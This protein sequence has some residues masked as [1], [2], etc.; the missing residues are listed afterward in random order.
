[1][2]TSVVGKIVFEKSDEQGRKTIPVKIDVNVE[3]KVK[4]LECLLAKEIE[5]VA[6][7]LR[8]NAEIEKKL[9]K[10]NRERD[11]WH[12][13]YRKL[14]PDK[15]ID[16]DRQNAMVVYGEIDVSEV[17]GNITRRIITRRRIMN[18]QKGSWW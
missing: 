6:E 16:C 5:K 2:A 15:K 3:K 8:E 11:C 18:R 4:K 13:L 7:L 14:N 10:A 9:E 12:K 17:L 1:M